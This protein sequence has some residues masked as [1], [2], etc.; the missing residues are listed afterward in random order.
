[1]REGEMTRDKS[2][3]ITLH[4]CLMSPEKKAIMMPQDCFVRK[5]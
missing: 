3:T 2:L 4:L 5:V 1:M